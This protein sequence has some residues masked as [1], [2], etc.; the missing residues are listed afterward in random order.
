M[1]DSS[2][3]G[4]AP[5]DSSAPEAQTSKKPATNGPLKW[6]VL[7]TAVVVLGAVWYT[8]ARTFLR[9]YSLHQTVKKLNGNEFRHQDVWSVD[10]RN[11]SVDDATVEKLASVLGTSGYERIIVNVSGTSITDESLKSLG[12]MANLHELYLNETAVTDAGMVHLRNLKRLA[13]IQLRGTKVTDKGFL[14]LKTCPALNEVNIE[15]TAVSND[16][17][18]EIRSVIANLYVGR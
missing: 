4:G 13:L 3:A 11:S 16:A 8:P 17:V 1:T 14:E 5:A 10:V 2:P 9:E 12:S 7:V 15:N 6:L 18:R